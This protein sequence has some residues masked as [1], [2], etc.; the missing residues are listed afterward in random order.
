MKEPIKILSVT[1]TFFKYQE[2]DWEQILSDEGNLL[3][4]NR[5]IYAEGSLAV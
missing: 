1:K 5:S 4:T 2:K 3:R